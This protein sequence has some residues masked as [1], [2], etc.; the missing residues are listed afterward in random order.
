MNNTVKIERGT[1]YG[2]TE[3]GVREREKKSDP[4]QQ[5]RTEIYIREKEI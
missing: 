4:G 3:S 1:A 5:N 2:I